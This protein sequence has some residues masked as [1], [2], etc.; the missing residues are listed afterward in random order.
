M[1][2]FLVILWV[3]QVERS[4]TASI[5]PPEDD[6]VSHGEDLVE[7]GR[8]DLNSTYTISRSKHENTEET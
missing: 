3:L 6:G 1:V 5:K 4:I 7:A 2:D 8:T